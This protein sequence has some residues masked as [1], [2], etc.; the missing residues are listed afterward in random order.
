[1]KNHHF[2]KSFLFILMLTLF[3]S[4]CSSN[5]ST[6]D[7]QG[8]E[9][10]TSEPTS[11]TEDTGEPKQGGELTV[12][13]IADPV[14]LDPH[15]ASAASTVRVIEHVYSGL[16]SQ[17]VKDY[18]SYLPDLAEKWDISDDNKTYT[19]YLVEGVKFHNGRELTAEDVK[20]SIERIKNPDL[21]SP[22]AYMFD[23]VE[24]INI[25]DNYT[26]EFKLSEP[27]SPLLSNLANSSNAIVPKEVVEEHGDLQNVAIGT[28][29]FVFEKWTPQTSIELTR[30]EDYH[31]ENLPYLDKVV[32]KP[33]PDDTARTTA[34]RTGSVDLIENVPQ[35][36][37]QILEGDSSVVVQ[38]GPGTFYDY[39][40]FN[41]NK[42]PFDNIKV[43]QAIAWAI[44]RQEIVDISLFG[45]GTV[46]DGGPIPNTHWAHADFKAYGPDL[47]K[48]KTLLSEAGYPDGFKAS[49]KVGAEYKSQVSIAQVVKEQLQP[50]GI[51]IEVQPTEWGLF[52][53]QWNKKEFDMV[54]LGWIGAVDPDDWLYAQFHSGEAWNAYGLDVPEIDALLEQ[55]QSI[56]DEA[57][58]KTIYQEVQKLIVEE[59]PYVFLH[60]NDQYEGLAPNLKGYVTSP[61]GSFIGLKEAWLDK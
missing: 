22:R 38:G 8:T 5:S 48:A 20:Y 24:S 56:A 47:D 15:L 10:N 14:G 61:T 44:N 2:F 12:A 28:G 58:R 55:G 45:Y 33:I 11:N 52:L 59:A 27:F 46:L 53:D 42:P 13:V 40:G 26:V 6:T 18:G 57:E 51:E 39:I 54:V 60:V 29:P 9:E 3:A 21:G 30:Y 41:M 4:G 32:L 1:M 50:L 36:D 16:L 34:L 31:V 23:K 49:I 43:R 25:I 19:F 35:K 7:S 37:V 17:D